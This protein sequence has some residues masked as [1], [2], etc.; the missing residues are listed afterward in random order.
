MI[1]WLFSK[2]WSIFFYP[3]LFYWL[4]SV[5]QGPF[6]LSSTLQ[7]IRENENFLVRLNEQWLKLPTLFQALNKQLT[8]SFNLSEHQEMCTSGKG[9]FEQKNVL[10]IRKLS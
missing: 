5:T 9:N 8:P 1:K 3:L 2:S 6:S 4:R 7:L 10:V